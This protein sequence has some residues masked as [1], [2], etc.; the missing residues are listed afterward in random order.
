MS[1]DFLDPAPGRSE[2]LPSE[3]YFDSAVFHRVR[4]SAFG[5]SWQ[6]VGD[7][8]RC[9]I[10]GQTHPFTLLEGLL[11]EP[12]LL[13]R[14]RDDQVRCL[15]NV[16]THRAALVCEGDSVVNHLRCRYHGRRFGLDGRLQHMPEF[17]GVEG[18]PAPSDNL[19]E[20][21]LTL[22]RRWFFCS[23]HPRLSA[24]EFFRPVEERVGFLPLEHFQPRPDRARDY[25]IRAHWALYV[26]NY[27]EGFHIP[28]IH[29][30]L[31][32]TLDYG[33]YEVLTFDHGVLQVG[34]AADGEPCFDLPAGHPDEGRRIAAYYFW[35]HPNLMLNFYPWGLSVNVVR[36]MGMNRTKVSFLPFVWDESKLDEGAGAALDRVERED[37]AVVESVQKGLKSRFYRAGRFSAA[38]E[39]GTHHFHRL[40]AADAGL[41]RPPGQPE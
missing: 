28:Y 4:E 27:L 33:S 15:S 30:A 1:S 26:D 12:L 25:M 7:L 35:L 9:R 2:T 36:P 20:V 32:S 39:N 19:T 11:D 8:D 41:V 37:E 13:A 29:A 6:W 24:E 14:D 10:P 23:L 31:N 16:C 22:W 34:P 3:F 5:G 17:E 21:P 40:L 18:F 38:R